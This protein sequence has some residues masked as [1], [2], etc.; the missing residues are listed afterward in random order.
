MASSAIEGICEPRFL[1][2]REV[3]AEN[4]AQHGEVGAAVALD[5]L[6]R[7]ARPARR[8]DDTCRPGCWS[9]GIAGCRLESAWSN[10]KPTYRCPT[11]R[12]AIV[13][14]QNNDHGA[15]FCDPHLDNLASQ[16]QA[17]QLTDPGRRLQAQF[18]R[19]FDADDAFLVSPG[20]HAPDGG[21]QR[22]LGAAR[23]ARVVLQVRA[24]A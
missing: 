10:G 18:E 2:V 4:F 22:V 9:A 16:A 13:D 20:K 6:R 12:N 7:A 3:F 8:C 5:R 1:G 21:G 14:C 23:R 15:G 24:N 19:R 17:A 11:A